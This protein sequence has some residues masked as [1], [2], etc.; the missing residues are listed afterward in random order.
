MI[1]AAAWLPAVSAT[2][3]PSSMTTLAKSAYGGGFMVG[4]N[5]RL[6]AWYR[7][8]IL[9]E[10]FL[11]RLKTHKWFVCHLAALP[12]G[13]SKALGCT[14]ACSESETGLIESSAARNALTQSRYDACHRVP[15][16]VEYHV[17]HGTR[18]TCL[19]HLRC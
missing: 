19:N 15:L 2:L 16:A 12:D 11:G 8:V 7:F 17:I 1:G 5:V 6:T 4:R 3:T 14:A 9:L 18:N 13:V 10:N